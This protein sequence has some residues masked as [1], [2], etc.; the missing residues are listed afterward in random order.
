VPQK[1]LVERD[2]ERLDAGL[3]VPSLLEAADRVLESGTIRTPQELEKLLLESSHVELVVQDQNPMWQLGVSLLIRGWKE[4]L[5]P[6]A[7]LQV[8]YSSMPVHLL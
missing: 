6:G 7:A 3:E 2:A 4:N 5:R 1:I 8:F